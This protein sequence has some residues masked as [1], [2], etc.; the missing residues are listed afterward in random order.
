MTISD[1]VVGYS[2][3]RLPQLLPEILTLR[4]RPAFGGT[5]TNTSMIHW[6]EEPDGTPLV[7]QSVFQVKGFLAP[8]V[9]MQWDSSGRLLLSVNSSPEV[10]LRIET[11]SN[12]VS[13]GPFQ[14]VAGGNRTVDLGIPTRSDERKYFRVVIL[15]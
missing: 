10:S 15:Q 2:I 7:S 5:F 1:G 13:W 3:G 9:S 4:I 14:T 12:L 6:N 11:S 8:I